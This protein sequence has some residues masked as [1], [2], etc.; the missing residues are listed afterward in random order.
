MNKLKYKI[1][2]SELE[3]LLDLTQHVL[4]REVFATFGDTM[5]KELMIEVAA[6]MAEMCN[7]YGA[8]KFTLKL[9]PAQMLAFLAFWR[10]QNLIAAPY[11]SVLIHDINKEIHKKMLE[12]KQEPF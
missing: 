3:A 4:Y 10:K 6:Q 5:V 7:R 12:V 8:K 1:S 9:S 2:R 11:E